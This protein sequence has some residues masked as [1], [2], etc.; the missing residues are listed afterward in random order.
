MTITLADLHELDVRIAA[1][2]GLPG[3][4]SNAIAALIDFS[5]M[6]PEGNPQTDAILKPLRA[7]GKSLDRVQNW[8]TVQQ[9]KLKLE[10]KAPK[11][12]PG[13]VVGDAAGPNDGLTPLEGP[14]L[15]DLIYVEII[16]RDNAELRERLGD[17]YTDYANAYGPGGRWYNPTMMVLATNP[18]IRRTYPSPRVWGERNGLYNAAELPE[19]WEGFKP[20][21]AGGFTVD[22]P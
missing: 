6:P 12:P 1:A 15:R 21:F 13:Q 14:D 20:T 5:G 4:V 19:Q 7:L 8:S 16:G 18:A 10:A 9:E 3:E 17:R 11:L 22:L 2:G